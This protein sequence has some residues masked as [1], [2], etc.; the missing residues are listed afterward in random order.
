M[1]EVLEEKKRVIS[2]IVPWGDPNFG[3]D[4]QWSRFYPYGLEARSA[5]ESDL[6]VV[7]LNH[8]P[9]AE[10]FRIRPNIPKGWKCVPAFAELHVEAHME[11]QVL[12]RV[13]P[14]EEAVG[15]TVLTADV[16]FR[17]HDLRQWIEAMVAVRP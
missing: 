15:L 5:E 14:G 17:N 7:V 8:L 13:T 1:V 12:F 11:G 2:E 16:S 4:E 9:E 10:T 3:V 6:Y